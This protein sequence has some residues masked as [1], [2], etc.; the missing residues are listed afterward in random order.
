[1]GAKWRLIGGI[2]ILGILVFG[3]VGWA[4]PNTPHVLI[5][6]VEDGSGVSP[7]NGDL[8]F[9]AWLTKDP[10]S[11]ITESSLSSLYIQ[12]VGCYFECANFATAWAF[13]DVV[14][15]EV[16]QI[17]TH[18]I[19]T[20]DFTLNYD[21]MQ[22]VAS[23]DGIIIAPLSEVWI[24]DD[25]TEGSCGG[26]NWNYDAFDTIQEG[27]N[28]VSGSTVNVAAGTYAGE[29]VIAKDGITLNGAGSAAVTIVATRAM[30][31]DNYGITIDADGVTISGLTIDGDFAGNQVAAF[32]DAIHW[33]NDGGNDATI[34]NVV[35]RYADRRGISVWPESV[36]GTRIASCT[37]EYV[38][39]VTFGYG[40]GIKMNGVG[41]VTDCT[42]R[43]ATCGIMGVAD[44]PG[45]VEITD[46]VITDL[47]GAT[48][49]PFDIGIN[50]WCK[51]SSS[52]VAIIENN[53]VTASVAD[54]GGIYLVRPGVGSRVAGNALTLTGVGGIGIETGWSNDWGIEISNNMI[55]MGRGGAGIVV[56]GSGSAASPM[57]ISGNTLVN[58][59]ADD[60]FDNN[61]FGYSLREV[62]LLLSSHEYTSRTGDAHYELHATVTG[63]TIDGFKDG[64]VMVKPDGSHTAPYRSIVVVA[65]DNGIENAETAGRFGTVLDNTGTSVFTAVTGPGDLAYELQD[66]SPNYWGSASPDFATIIKG[67]VDYDPWYMD[68]GM[69]TLS[70]TRVHN[71]TQGTWYSTI[72][73]AIDGA[74]PEAIVTASTGTYNEHITID[75]ALTLKA[76][77]SPVIDAGGTGTAVTIAASN[78]N[79][80]GFTIRNAVTG[81]LVSSGSGNEL[82]FSNII[83]N[84]TWGVN[85]TSGNLVD[86]ED[87][88]WGDGSGPSGEGSGTGDAV[89]TN[90]DFDPW[91]GM[92]TETVVFEADVS[93]GGTVENAAA[94]VGVTL[95]D[96]TGTTDITIAEY[97]SPPPDTPSFGAGATY[98]DV[99]LSDPSG[100]QELSI[101]FE[102]MAAGTVIYFYL[103]GTGWIACSHQSQAGGTITVT[104]TDSTVPTLAQLTGT[105]FAEGTALGNINGDGV[106]DVLDVRLCLQIATGFIEGTG[107]QQAAA[108]VDQDG[109]VD[110]TD[111]QILAKYIIGIRT[112]L[113]GGGSV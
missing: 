22:I 7:A 105:I 92:S 12:G 45:T 28:A 103:P 65:E 26:H 111:A 40:H 71:V 1:L 19:G 89:S 41:T 43:Y 14:H 83:N 49:T 32:K 112:A 95:D 38:T 94:G 56:T 64:I 16:E 74:A 34:E 81:V 33:S 30:A 50:I 31:A 13:G 70:N 2:L 76:G 18:D 91:T 35:I 79:I 100:V 42:I 5:V 17:S 66:A 104:V 53:T 36:T 101:K 68:A 82:H 48:D 52:P 55:T 4:V 80:T 8:T 39:G 90:V 63:N 21:S 62:G 75:K 20:G 11:V 106:I 46:N 86:A 37:V 60:S 72:Q 113:P 57:T 73:S 61:Y 99:Q 15:I 96:A 93:Q 9:E 109:D 98:V 78:V 97:T 51:H 47:T 87:N 54:N 69:T 102:G 25:Y 23:P 110:L 6:N 59:G 27:I 77:S 88:Y 108:D 29:I 24:D 84:T 3:A 67:A 107:A 58:V 44:I 10:E 85:N